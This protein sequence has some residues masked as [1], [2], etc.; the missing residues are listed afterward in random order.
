MR[1]GRWRGLAARGK[2]ML[3]KNLTASLVF[4]AGGPPSPR[5]TVNRVLRRKIMLHC[6]KD[7][8]Y[9]PRNHVIDQK[10]PPSE[11]DHDQ[12]PFEIP[13]ELRDF[14][15][16]SVDQA[17]KAFEGF[18]SV[19]QKTIGAADNAAETAQKNAK[20]VGA[21]ALSFTEQ[22]INAALDLAQKLVQAKDPQEAFAVQSEFLKSQLANLQAQAKEIGALIQKS[23]TPDAK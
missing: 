15:E 20:S 4:P 23:A 7:L 9:K 14:A 12:S 10:T 2:G 8:I 18:V 13:N 22:N 16:R 1:F 21:Q 11:T 3:T 19:A 17:R 6:N 5:E